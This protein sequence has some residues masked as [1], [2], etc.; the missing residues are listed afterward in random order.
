MYF[1]NHLL[2]EYTW[3]PQ[4]SF[5]IPSGSQKKKLWLQILIWVSSGYKQIWEVWDHPR[6]QN[7]R[8]LWKKSEPM[9][10]IRK[11]QSNMYKSNQEIQENRKTQKPRWTSSKHQR[12]PS[13]S[14][15]STASSL[16]NSDGTVLKSRQTWIKGNHSLDIS[17]ILGTTRKNAD[18]E[19]WDSEVDMALAMV[20]KCWVLISDTYQMALKKLLYSSQSSS[21]LLETQGVDWSALCSQLKQAP[22]L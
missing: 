21:S 4:G 11:Q 22:F 17:F 16:G 10:E 1:S 14:H 19:T 6:E 13:Y 5:S 8:G 12:A 7:T 3:M 18:M 20:P 15:P 2:W 9:S